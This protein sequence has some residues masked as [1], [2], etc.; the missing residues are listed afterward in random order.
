MSG[1][2]RLRARYEREPEPPA[3]VP[4]PAETEPTPA[5]PSTETPESSPEATRE[6]AGSPLASTILT[7]PAPRTTAHAAPAEAAAVPIQSDGAVAS[8]EVASGGEPASWVEQTRPR[9]RRVAALIFLIGLAVV[10]FTTGLVLFNS[11]VMP[12]IIHGVGEVEVPNLAN[13]TLDQAEQTLRPLDLRLSRA[14]E[15]FD[16]GLPK[17]FILSQDPPAGTSVRG[18]RRISVMV[19]LGEEFSS[20]PELI[21]ESQRSAE[22]LL[23][24]AGLRLGGVTRAPSEEVG[25]GLI[26]GTD[27]GPEAVLEHDGEVGLLI[28]SGAGEE[29]F[30]MPDLAGRDQAAVRRQLES[31]GFRVIVLPRDGSSGMILGQSPLPGARITQATE[32]RLEPASRAR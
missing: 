13:L 26:A 31:M 16:P 2:R 5:V 21:G 28:S 12:R 19:S 3:V 11:V 22:A 29:E 27:P 4:A 25:E 30:V 17:G 32:I 18:G 7:L 6:D 14:G 23:R 24:S 8:V 20:V 10:A 15:R 9:A 1:R